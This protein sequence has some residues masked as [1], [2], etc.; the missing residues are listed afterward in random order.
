MLCIVYYQSHRW[1]EHYY[2]IGFEGIEQFTNIIIVVNSNINTKIGGIFT[3]TKIQSI[4]DK[5]LEL[6]E[7]DYFYWLNLQ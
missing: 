3:M 4:R 1:S 6:F 7:I 2:D 5:L